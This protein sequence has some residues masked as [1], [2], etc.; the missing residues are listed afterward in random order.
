MLE[1]ITWFDR[2]TI[3][4]RLNGCLVVRVSRLQMNSAGHLDALTIYPSAFVTHQHLNCAANII[5]QPDSPQ[6]GL[7]GNHC[8]QLLIV[9][10]CT[11]AEIRFNRAKVRRLFFR[12]IVRY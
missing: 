2:P 5:G 12:M 1:D 10:N 3:L 11:T 7:T 6:C 9:A 8:I 4:H